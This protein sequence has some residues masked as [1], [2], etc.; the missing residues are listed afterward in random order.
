MSTKLSRE[1]TW[2][3]Y[4]LIVSKMLGDKSSKE[5]SRQR[6]LERRKSVNSMKTQKRQKNLKRVFLN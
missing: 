5:D 3:T 2:R 1:V 6:L 4:S